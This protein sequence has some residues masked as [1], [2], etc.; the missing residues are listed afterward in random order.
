MKNKGQDD[1]VREEIKEI[2]AKM[3]KEWMTTE[4]RSLLYDGAGYQAHLVITKEEE[5]FLYSDGEDIIE[6]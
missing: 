4:M 1:K 5:D 2:I 3:G 6:F